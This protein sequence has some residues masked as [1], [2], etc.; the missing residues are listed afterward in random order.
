[1]DAGEGVPFNPVVAFGLLRTAAERG[2]PESQA[3]LAFRLALGTYP[4]HPGKLSHI[5]GS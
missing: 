1:M 2:D 4:P 3:D 5:K